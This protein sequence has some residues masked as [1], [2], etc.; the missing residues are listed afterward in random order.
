MSYHTIELQGL[1]IS[2]SIGFQ[3][4]ANFVAGEINQSYA[5]S[6]PGFEFGK[7]NYIYSK[8][9]FWTFFHESKKVVD[10]KIILRITPK[11]NLLPLSQKVTIIDA[12]FGSK[13]KILSYVIL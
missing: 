2:I 12:V 13:N 4:N 11:R 10:K 1:P 3:L 7:A 6:E 5:K 8:R 9:V